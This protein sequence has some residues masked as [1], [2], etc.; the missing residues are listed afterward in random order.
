MGGR[1]TYALGNDVPFT[2]KTVGYIEGIKILEGLPGH[3]GLPEEAHSSSAYILLHPDGKFHMLREYDEEHYLVRDIAYHCETKLSGH[4]EPVLHVHEYGRDFSSR[5][6]RLLTADEQ[7]K[8]K[9]YL[10]GIE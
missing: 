10:R 9:K 2:Y 1:G 7:L 6:T 3:K 8:Y 5:S 4:H